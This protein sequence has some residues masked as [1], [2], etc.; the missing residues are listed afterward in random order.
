MKM[1]RQALALTMIFTTPA[2]A[3][4]CQPQAAC[5]TE[6]GCDAT[7]FEDPFRLQFEGTDLLAYALDEDGTPRTPDTPEMRL[8]EAAQTGEG[9]RVF[10]SIDAETGDA[11]L[12]T[13]IGDRAFNL[14]L[15]GTV[16]GGPFG[17]IASGT[18]E[19]ALP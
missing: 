13:V 1:L 7:L 16:F 5:T 2:L 17:L 14:S 12:L 6:G 8:T 10:T 11:T 4:D 9:L 15:H 19:G 3:L 18:C